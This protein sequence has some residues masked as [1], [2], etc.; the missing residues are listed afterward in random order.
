MY[1]RIVKCICLAA[2]VLA[3]VVTLQGIPEILFQ[4]VVC[5]GALFVMVEAVRN[6]QYLWVAAFAVAALY[7]NPVLPIA[8]S[9]TASRPIVLLCAL[10]FLGSLR[11]LSPKPRMSLATITDLPARGESL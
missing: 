3:A 1:S 2:L 11:Y 4:L 10:A 5:G 6:H 7:C 9:Q 8:L